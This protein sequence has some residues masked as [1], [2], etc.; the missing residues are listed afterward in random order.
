MD[1]LARRATALDPN[2]AGYIVQW[3]MQTGGIPLVC[4]LVGSEEA[5]KQFVGGF[6]AMLVYRKSHTLCRFSSSNNNNCSS[7]RPS[8]GWGRN[9]AHFHASCIMAGIV[10]ILN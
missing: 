1:E 3:A 6:Q 2:N 4:Q 8:H 10:S 9:N 5:L 7:R